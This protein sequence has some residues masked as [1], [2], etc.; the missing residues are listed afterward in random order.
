MTMW[1]DPI[2]TE[3]RRIREE[4]AEQDNFDVGTIFV[5]MRKRQSTLGPRLVCRKK[6]RRR[7]EQNKRLYLTGIPPRSIEWHRARRGRGKI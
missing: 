2:V 7:I 5:G 6:E 1:E 4:L 3:V